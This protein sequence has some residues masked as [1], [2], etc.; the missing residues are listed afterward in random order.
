VQV[1]EGLAMATVVEASGAPP[2][3]VIAAVVEE[4]RTVTETTTPKRH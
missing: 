2:L 3:P 4:G 1:E